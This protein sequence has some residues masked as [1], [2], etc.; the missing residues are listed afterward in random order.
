MKLHILSD[1]HLDVDGF[2]APRTDAD[3]VVLAGDIARPARAIDWALRLE[4]PVVYV[5]GNH[6]FYGSS[7][8]ATVLALR[9]R[10]A[11]TPVHFL[12]GDAQVIGGVRFL[13]ATLW[14]DF[15]VYGAAERDRA[16]QQ[17]QRSLRDFS[18]IRLKEQSDRLF[19]PDDAAALFRREAGWLAGELGAAFDGPTVV[20]THHAPSALSIHPRFEG[21]LLNACFVSDAEHL[22]AGDRAC[23]WI[24]GHTHDS[25]DYRVHGTRVVCNPRGYARA[26]VNEN[27]AFDAG[28]VVDLDAIDTAGA[29]ARAGSR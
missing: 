12:S 24:H 3:V 13:G 9:M 23:L 20:V 1:L 7:I 11:G 4:R 5:A 10:C 21:T 18:R 15:L 19:A 27:A 16:M 6:E 28:L 25:F 29:A 14:T 8:E 22:L 26:G 17:A 2:E